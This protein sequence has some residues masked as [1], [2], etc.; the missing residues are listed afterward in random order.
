MQLEE[1]ISLIE[2]TK[3]KNEEIE[4]KN[5]VYEELKIE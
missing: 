2:I 3:M 1:N 4:G 5:L